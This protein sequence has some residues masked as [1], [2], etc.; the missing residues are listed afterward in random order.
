MR[1][2]F[3]LLPSSL[4]LLL[5]LPSPRPTTPFTLPSSPFPRR[6]LLSLS[7]AIP[8][9]PP[10]P[11]PSYKGLRLLEWTNGLISQKALVKTARTSWNMLWKILMTELAPQGKDGEYVRPTYSFTD[12]L[13]SPAFPLEEG[14]YH[15]YVGNACPWCHRLTL[16][17]ALRGLSQSQLS[18]SYAIDDPERASRGGW[19]FD[20]MGEGG[21]GEAGAPFADPVFGCRDLRE[22][23]DLCAP[24]YTGRCTAPV[25]VDVKRRRIVNNESSD[26]LRFLNLFPP[27]PGQTHPDVDLFPPS[28]RPRILEINAWVYPLIN[29]GVYR[30]GFATSQAAY[31]RSVRDV[32]RGLESVEAILTDQRFLAGDVLTEADVRLFPT[33]IR[34]DAVYASLFKCAGKRIADYPNLTQWMREVYQIPGVRT[35]VDIPALI[36]SYFVQLFPLNPSGI[37]PQ[38]PTEEDLKVLERHDR[39]ERFVKAG[40]GGSIFA[41]KGEEDREGGT[42]GT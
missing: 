40:G 35:T 16:A 34:F 9:S 19:A 23:Y 37:C 7:P 2:F 21:G 8:P 12:S 15:L 4:L 30:C 29:N 17:H 6:R 11:P 5:L 32:F 20:T 42:E 41:T 24:G 28:L 3:R 27:P 22:V 39:E 10:P 1:S 25:L 26:L 31:D 33:V 14:R 18:Y 38:G 13:G 36:R